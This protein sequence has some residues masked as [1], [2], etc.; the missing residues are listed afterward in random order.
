MKD[1]DENFVRNEPTLAGLVVF[2]LF[3]VIRI[4]ASN[5]H[6]TF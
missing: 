6:M 2:A 1:S 3:V 4:I 5:V